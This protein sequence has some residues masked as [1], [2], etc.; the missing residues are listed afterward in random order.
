MPSKIFISVPYA[1]GET[2][3]WECPAG[4]GLVGVR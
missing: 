1:L 2:E 3:P 4:R